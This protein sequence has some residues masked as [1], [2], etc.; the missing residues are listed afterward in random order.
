MVGIYMEKA[1]VSRDHL[2]G[3]REPVYGSRSQQPLAG[4]MGRLLTTDT[5]LTLS[6]SYA[7][8]HTRTK[9]HKGWVIDVKLSINTLACGV[10]KQ[11]N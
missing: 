4:S 2:Q 5:K 9:T 11:F 3:K 10:A 1:S 6:L 8:T 7:C